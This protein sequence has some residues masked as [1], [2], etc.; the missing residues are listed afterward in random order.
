MKTSFINLH[1]SNQSKRKFKSTVNRTSG[2]PAVK[3]LTVLTSDP[4]RLVGHPVQIRSSGWSSGW[5]ELFRFDS[6]KYHFTL[7][8]LQQLEESFL[9]KYVSEKSCLSLHLYIHFIYFFIT[10]TLIIKSNFLIHFFHQ[11]FSIS[12]CA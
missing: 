10:K 3:F 8:S 2:S 4:Q 12:L 9:V 1:F 5:A 11:S 7:H 6:Y